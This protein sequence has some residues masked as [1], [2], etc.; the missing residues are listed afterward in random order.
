[1]KSSADTILES[2]LTTAGQTA[3][4]SELN[5]LTPHTIATL[6]DAQLDI[7]FSAWDSQFYQTDAG[8]MGTIWANKTP[9]CI[10]N[11]LTTAQV[12]HLSDA[13]F[14]KIIQYRYLTDLRDEFILGIAARFEANLDSEMQIT[15]VNVYLDNPRQLNIF[16]SWWE[17]PRS[18]TDKHDVH[19]V[20]QGPR[21]I[22]LKL[23]QTLTAVDFANMDIAV[24]KKCIPTH[25]VPL[26]GNEYARGIGRNTKT[27][28]QL[29]ATFAQIHAMNQA[30]VN[31]FLQG[32][33]AS[34]YTSSTIPAYA[35]NALSSQQIAWADAKYFAKNILPSEVTNL[36]QTCIHALPDTTL[37]LISKEFLQS[38]H[39]DII[40]KLS[41][42]FLSIIAGRNITEAAFNPTNATFTLS[43]EQF[44]QM[45]TAQIHAYLSNWISKDEDKLIFT[46]IPTQIIDKL[47][48]TAISS[49]MDQLENTKELIT[50]CFDF[51]HM[52]KNNPHIKDLI[53]RIG[54]FFWHD[55]QKN[56]TAWLDAFCNESFQD[57]VDTVEDHFLCMWYCN[58]A[59]IPAP[60]LNK[61]SPTQFI[62]LCNTPSFQHKFHIL[63]TET[64]L[65]D[66]N[67]DLLL[68]I[69]PHLFDPVLQAATKENDKNSANEEN[70]TDEDLQALLTKWHK[71]YGHL[72]VRDKAQAKHTEQHQN[73]HLH[74]QRD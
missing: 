18:Y 26:L 13:V 44:T 43:A 66:L 48:P 45:S 68:G 63:V 10:L 23:L 16:F 49:W 14:T 4:Q 71:R 8:G 28:G 38:I 21:H 25:A 1:M 50:Q 22:P 32:L 34:Y 9:A 12:T 42:H 11:A 19:H 58:N 5:I 72:Y 55:F 53:A 54:L 61:F 31:N 64:S 20:M 27:H 30:Q 29:A 41:P 59:A 51:K 67:T 52:D 70:I 65:G 60:L 37:Q 6:T 17:S 46:R 15:S 39:V 56:S 33:S 35:F 40:K 7:Y 2:W 47:A 69:P 3:S 57:M 62:R 24:L 36:S 73:D 74:Q